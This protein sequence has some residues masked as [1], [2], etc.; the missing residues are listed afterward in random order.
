MGRK[1]RAQLKKKQSMTSPRDDRREG[2]AL[3]EEE[4]LSDR[5]LRDLWIE[6]DSK[7]KLLEDD[8]NKVKKI[9]FLMKQEYDDVVREKDKLKR[10]K[11][12]WNEKNQG[13][14][15]FEGLIYRLDHGREARNLKS[16]EA[17]Q[18]SA[19]LQQAREELSDL[20]RQ[21]EELKTE[22]HTYQTLYG[23]LEKGTEEPTA[24]PS[25]M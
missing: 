8:T 15:H 5:E 1:T 18:L 10:E 24:G 4:S 17:N 20:I 14:E 23:K 9:V 3:E 2:D 11:T 7:M 16:G 12:A 13:G 19:S 6:H 21:N 25:D 22:L